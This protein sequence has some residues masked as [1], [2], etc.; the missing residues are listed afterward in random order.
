[1]VVKSGR[2][3]KYQEPLPGQGHGQIG[4]DSK[5]QAGAAVLTSMVL[6]SSLLQ[7]EPVNFHIFGAVYGTMCEEQGAKL[8]SDLDTVFPLPG[9]SPGKTT[10][11]GS[12]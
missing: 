2:S 12:D 8:E 3:T 5:S 1:M 7:Q 11:P 6:T 4:L 9:L 10:H